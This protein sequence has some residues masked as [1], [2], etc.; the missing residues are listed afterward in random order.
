MSLH[1]GLSDCPCGQCVHQCMQHMDCAA[2]HRTILVLAQS[3]FR[4]KTTSDCAMS[5]SSSIA[6]TPK[7]SVGF[8]YRRTG[9]RLEARRTLGE[10]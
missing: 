10:R 9:V 4:T 1:S 2:S 3:R 7:D 5:G 6:V 8:G